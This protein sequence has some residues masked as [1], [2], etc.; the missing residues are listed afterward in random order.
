MRSLV[1][2]MQGSY[3]LHTMCRK[4][5]NIVVHKIDREPEKAKLF[6]PT[7]EKMM[8]YWQD[9][10][11]ALPDGLRTTGPVMHT[12]GGQ[13]VCVTDNRGNYWVLEAVPAT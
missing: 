8:T 3:A 2:G 10:D 5:K 11:A 9:V 6:P 12:R 1:S 13:G 7:S 4:E